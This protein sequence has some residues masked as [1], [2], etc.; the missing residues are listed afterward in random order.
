MFCSLLF[1]ELIFIRS[2]STIDQISVDI[3]IM[4]RFHSTYFNSISENKDCL[5]EASQSRDNICQVQYDLFPTNI[6][7][8]NRQ[9]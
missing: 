5:E 3:I 9:L 2:T 4:A 6:D 8:H 1:L 7:T